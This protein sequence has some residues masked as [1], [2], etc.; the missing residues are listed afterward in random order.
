MENEIGRLAQG[1]KRGVKG[2]NT[3]IFIKITDVPPG[4]KS[5]YGSLTHEE[6][7]E[8]TRLKIGGNQI[9]YLGDQ[10]TCTAGLTTAKMLFNSTISTPGAKFLVIDII[11][12]YL[13]T[14]LERYEDMVMIA[15]LP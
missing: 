2:T 12:S 15:S 14:P 3:I 10:S 11:F 9:E 8:R 13:S 4:H 1:L 6:E 5:T 7:T